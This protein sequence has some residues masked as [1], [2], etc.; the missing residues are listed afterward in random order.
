MVSSEWGLPYLPSCQSM[1]CTKV[2]HSPAITLNPATA[3]LRTPGQGVRSI[4]RS[5]KPTRI[6]KGMV[7]KAKDRFQGSMY[8]FE[9]E[10]FAATD[11][12]DQ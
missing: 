9:T 12:T 7:V 5:A 4:V 11:R 6:I 8:I 10:V 1:Q 3:V 2:A